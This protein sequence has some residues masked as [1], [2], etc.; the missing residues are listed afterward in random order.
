MTNLLDDDEKSVH[1]RRVL[2]VEYIKKFDEF[3]DEWD[4]HKAKTVEALRQLNSIHES[5]VS[6]APYF[7]NFQQLPVIASALQSMQQVVM[8]QNSDLISPAT[9]ADKMPTK[10][11]IYMLGICFIFMLILGSA[12]IL[13]LI[14]ESKKDFSLGGKDGLHITTSDDNADTGNKTSNKPKPSTDDR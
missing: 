8:K 9:S 13:V 6:S 10:V 3:L 2:V 14:R 4:K 5:I 11:T 12:L 7:E 1:L